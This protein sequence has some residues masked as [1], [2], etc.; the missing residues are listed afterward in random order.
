MGIEIVDVASDFVHTVDDVEIYGRNDKVPPRSAPRRIHCR[1]AP[2]AAY[3][4]GG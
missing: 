2:S 1:F 4:L 3:S